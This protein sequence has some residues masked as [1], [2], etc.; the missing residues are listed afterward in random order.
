MTS[1]SRC[2]LFLPLFE[3]KLIEVL[4][5]IQS[6]K[7]MRMGSAMACWKAKHPDPKRKTHHKRSKKK[8]PQKIKHQVGTPCYSSGIP[9]FC[10]YFSLVAIRVLSFFFV[11]VFHF[12]PSP[13]IFFFERA[14]PLGGS[15][16]KM[17]NKR[18]VASMVAVPTVDRMGGPP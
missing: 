18:L 6:G 11:V 1:A 15:E 16:K 9:F 14:Q 17:P 3:Q 8:I 12:F 4:L 7:G 5:A 10:L 2:A 13:C